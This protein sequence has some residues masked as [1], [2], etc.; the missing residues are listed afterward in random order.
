[1]NLFDV[2]VAQGLEPPRRFVAPE[3]ATWKIATH[4]GFEEDENE[5]ESEKTTTRFR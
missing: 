3:D 1:M 5:E 2:A 4:L